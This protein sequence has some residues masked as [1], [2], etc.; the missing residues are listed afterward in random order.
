MNKIA[1][2]LDSAADISDVKANEMGYFII[3]MPLMVDD[4]QYIEEKEMTDE[5]MIKLMGEGK[6]FKTAQPI[7]GDILKVWEE[8]LKTHDQ[9][10]YL[11]I[12]K[13]LSGTYQSA[14]VLAQDYPNKVFVV[15]NPSVCAPAL[16]LAGYTKQMIAQGMDA[17]TI[18][19]KLEKG[20]TYATLV[21]QD[22]Q[23]LKRGGRVSS[24]VALVASALK[25]VPV[26]KIE[27]GAVSVL[28]KVRT[29]KKA[30]KC[31][32]NA[33]LEGI[34]LQAYDYVVTGT[35]D[36]DLKPYIEQF[37]QMILS[38][39]MIGTIRAVVLAHTGPG[40]V[41]FGRIKKIL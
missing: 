10:I 7:L 16:V 4:K 20:E 38:K 27:N 17:Q 37:Q 29:H 26:L 31:A 3:R 6:V 21:P 30:I 35:K 19:E 5:Q 40:T 25:I 15:D 1:I 11:P 32:M 36:V 28:E 8:V 33:V 34:D 41:G 24:A 14:K 13:E 18:C 12:T 23:Y 39:P 9:L 22:I 2:V